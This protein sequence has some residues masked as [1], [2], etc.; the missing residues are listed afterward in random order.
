MSRD[1]NEREARGPRLSKGKPPEDEPPVVAIDLDRRE[2]TG[3]DSRRPIALRLSR[4]S[5]SAFSARVIFRNVTADVV[6]IFRERD[7]GRKETVARSC[8]KTRIT[9]TRGRAHFAFCIL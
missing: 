4:S 1:I 7:R 2:I 3:E 9:E 6:E 5:S 8:Q